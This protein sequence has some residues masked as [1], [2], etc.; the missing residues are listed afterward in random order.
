MNDFIKS[1]IKW[2]HQKYK[3]YQKIVVRTATILDYKNQ[4]VVSEVISRHKVEYQ[5]YQTKGWREEKC[6][7]G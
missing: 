3:T 4:Q 2:K 1:K 6:C 5:N 7:W